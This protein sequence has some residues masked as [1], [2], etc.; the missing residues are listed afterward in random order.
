MSLFANSGGV[1]YDCTGWNPEVA[2]RNSSQNPNAGSTLPF[3][4]I[5]VLNVF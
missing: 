4:P 1:E 3:Y 5:M 2:K